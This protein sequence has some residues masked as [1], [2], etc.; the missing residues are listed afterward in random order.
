MKVKKLVS[1]FTLLLAVFPSAQAAEANEGVRKAT[2]INIITDTFPPAQAAEAKPN[3]VFI[4]VDNL[5]YGELGVYGGGITRGAPTPQIDSLANEGFRLLNMNMEAQCTPSRSAMMTGRWAIRSGTYSVPWNTQELDGLTQWEV[6]I[7]EALSDIGY[8]TA[9]YGKWHLG[10]ANGRLPNDQGFDE[11]WGI[12]RTSDQTLWWVTPGY[13]PSLVPPEYIMT[14]LKG[15]KSQP[16]GVYNYSYRPLIDAE[17]TSKATS[18][19]KQNASIGKPFFVSV[20]LTQPHLPT[21]PNPNFV[22]GYDT[23]DGHVSG[24]DTKNGNWANMLA[25]MDYNVG[26]ILKTIDEANIRDK[27]IVIFT[28]DNGAEYIKPWDGWSGPWRGAYFT[29]LEG[30]I[31]VPFMI[32]WPGKIPAG[33]VSNEIVHGVDMFATLAHFTGAR[34]PTDR[35]IDSIDQTDFFLGKTQQ[36]NRTDFPVFV[37]ERLQ[38]VKWKNWKMHYYRQDTMVDPAE[39]YPGVPVMYDLYADP[40]EEKPTIAWSLDILD[41]VVKDFQASVAKCPLIP[42]STPDPYYPPSTCGQLT[43]PAGR[44]DVDE[45]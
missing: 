41:Q 10:S 6:T 16:V 3:I 38:A 30:G 17:I 23:P 8:A 27:T 28:S 24:H 39:Q 7:A 12:P 25:E 40:R 31:R 37:S 35:P 21:V 18:Y 34:V 1:A 33:V 44:T 13:D 9:L 5:G 32:R 2:P 43:R 20:A 4:L 36:S 14:G 29:A 19:I 42:M 15:Q 11:W 45:R 22:N 26:R